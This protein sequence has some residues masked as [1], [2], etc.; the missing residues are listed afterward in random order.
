MEVIKLWATT[1]TL[2]VKYEKN[3][4][5]VV[6]TKQGHG[7]KARAWYEAGATQICESPLARL[8]N[9]AESFISSSQILAVNPQLETV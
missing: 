8:Y 5:A 1:Q 3:I 7:S 4:W 9:Y 2:L 6:Y